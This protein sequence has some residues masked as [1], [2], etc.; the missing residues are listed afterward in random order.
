[1]K[2]CLAYGLP[3]VF[4]FTVFESFYTREVAKTGMMK[5]PEQEEKRLGGHAVL[6]VGYDDSLD[7]G[8]FIVRNSW[9]EAW[10]D[11]GYFYMP[12]DYLLNR[13]LSNDF[14]VIQTVE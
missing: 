4:G 1:M 11:Q 9:G 7:G 14:W 10:G 12:Y 13:G 8:R 6:A 3:F 2:S 5:W